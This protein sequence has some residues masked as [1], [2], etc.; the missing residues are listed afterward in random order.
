MSALTTRLTSLSSKS[1]VVVVS[2]DGVPCDFTASMAGTAPA[3]PRLD[4]RGLLV[5]VEES[6]TILDRQQRMQVGG[7]ATIVV[8]DRNN[9][10][11]SLFAVR[12]F[13]S[14]YITALVSKTATTV[15]MA[16]TTTLAS[17]GVVYVGS[18]T[19]QYTGKTGTTLTGCTRGAF[20]SK[21]Q[22]HRGGAETGNGVYTVP[23][24][25]FGRRVRLSVQFL[26]DDGRPDTSFGT[27]AL[28]TFRLEAGAI[29]K[30]RGRW[31]LRCS[32][33]S[34]EVTKRKLGT[35]IRDLDGAFVSEPETTTGGADALAIWLPANTVLPTSATTPTLLVVRTKSGSRGATVT[36]DGVLYDGEGA[37][38]HEILETSTVPGSGQLVVMVS[39]TSQSDERFGLGYLVG[40]LGQRP[41]T[42]K[43][44]QI[45][46]LNSAAP[47]LLRALTSRI[48]DG[49]NGIY[50]ALPGVEATVQGGPV[51]RFGAGIEAS[52]VDT[53]SVVAA[54]ANASGW[55]WVIDEEIPVGELLRD[56]CR[57]SNTAAVFNA[58][59]QLTFTPML[60]QRV[61]ASATI[62]EA[63]VIGDIETTVDEGAVYSRVRL[64]C[65]YDP[66]DGESEGTFDIIDEEIAETYGDSENTLVI[67]SRDLVVEPVA[68]TGDGTLIRPAT[69]FSEL[70]PVFR[71]TMLDGRGGSLLLSFRASAK[72]LDR[73]LGDFVALSMPSVSDYRGGSLAAAQGRIV[74]R[75]PDWQSMTIE[76][77][78]LVTERL[79][80]FAPFA[81]VV[82]TSGS[83]VISAAT[84]GTS[85]PASPANSFR[86]G[87]VLKVYDPVANV[88]V[89]D[90]VQVTGIP[91]TISLNLSNAGAAPSLPVS[92]GW[93]LM[94]K[95]STGATSTDG[96]APADYTFGNGGAVP[97][98]W[99]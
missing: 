77:T 91:S 23:P 46:V 21:A 8:Q 9:L 75:Q 86:V 54:S 55:S 7:G 13:R 88:V 62:A 4:G 98:R 84:F 53:A 61:G 40:T 29:D 58:A 19:I 51:V 12:S 57:A 15:P 52:E 47:S 56:F 34:D 45:C 60:D 11:R 73:Q 76:L 3:A 68:K 24:S 2:I 89:G 83:V 30:G 82:S 71:R 44:R 25:W 65:N 49:A 79:F 36:L 80:H 1:A 59:G 93:V 78:V 87:D 96:F 33:L 63:D 95:T 22:A 92:P 20:G 28:A 85:S 67:E 14:T 37:F 32:H 74:E 90:G 48:G 5:S 26:D 35:G 27:E 42:D 6:R 16:D 72:H 39:P 70:L 18:E 17:S 31:E 97:S 81:V 41:T 38:V 94:L 10:L 50:D 69:Q 43:A 99:R 64:E 66:V